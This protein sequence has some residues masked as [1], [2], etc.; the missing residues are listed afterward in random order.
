M[1]N[2]PNKLD[3]SSDQRS[4]L[5][6]ELLYCLHVLRFPGLLVPLSSLKFFD[7]NVFF[8]CF[9]S[10]QDQA[11]TCSHLKVSRIYQNIPYFLMFRPS[12][13]SCNTTENPAFNL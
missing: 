9:T 11:V 13:P 6:D 1:S 5:K 3:V 7:F 2:F 12:D 10:L 4:L 8:V